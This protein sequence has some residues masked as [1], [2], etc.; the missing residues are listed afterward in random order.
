MTLRAIIDLLRLHFFFAWPVLFCSGYLLAASVY[1]DFSW[2]DLFRAVLIG[3][4]GFE[5]GFV[6]NDYVDREYDRKDIESDRLTRY[7]RVFGTRPLPAGLVTR[8]QA[9]M[10]FMF[11]VALTALLIFT[12][13]FPHSLFVFII[14]ACSYAIEVFYQVKKR[15]QHF[16]IAQLVGRTDFALFPVAGYLCIGYPDIPALLYFLFFYPFA[17]AHL[18]VNDLAD[19]A[20]DQAR[21]MYSITVL[22]GEPGS[23]S[24]IAGFSAVHACTSLIFMSMLGGIAKTGLMAG[25]GLLLAANVAILRDRSPDTG[26]RVLPLFHITML[27]YAISILLDAVVQQGPGFV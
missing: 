16:P 27:I 26:L 12:L 3:F 21:G 10:L 15:N 20:N 22:Y 7:W 14:M 4:F 17:L 13:P 8:Y 9:L 19:Y 1:G 5:A 11:L 24:W 2:T 18:G 23:A 6:L 25:L